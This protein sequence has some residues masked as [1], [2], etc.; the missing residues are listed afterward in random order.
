MAEIEARKSD[1]FKPL[2]IDRVLNMLG[3]MTSISIPDHDFEFLENLVI[4]IE[5][6]LTQKIPLIIPIENSSG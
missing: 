4:D 6:S 3:D 5:K 2:T 1:P